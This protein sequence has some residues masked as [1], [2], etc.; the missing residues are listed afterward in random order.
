[1]VGPLVFLAA[2]GFGSEQPP[3]EV[4]VNTAKHEIVFRL[5]PFALPATSGMAEHEGM[6]HHGAEFPVYRFALPVGGWLRGFRIV[7]QDSAGQALPRRLLHHVNLLQLGRRQLTEPVFERTLGGGQETADVLLPK[8]VGIRVHAGDEMGLLTAWSN[9]AGCELPAVIL[10][11]SVPY[12]PENTVPHP[13]EVFP[14]V[15]D[16][17][18]RPGFPDDFDLDTGRTVH[19]RELVVPLDGHLLG[20]GGHLHDYAESLQLVEAGSGK[21][22]VALTPTLDSAGR[23]SGVSRKIFGISGPGLKLKA[24]RYLVVAVYRN[25]T[26]A[27][28]EHG[29]MAVIGGLFAPEDPRRWPAL[30]RTDAVFAADAAGLDRIGWSVVGMQLGKP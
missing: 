6:H 27:L 30:D 11:L 13:R 23:I 15:F 3:F 12:L 21:V 24:G 14:A 9:E 16:A 26:G 25:R 5:G 22:I 10:E 1:M 28:I 18:F 8:S 4:R 20:V 2:L 29:G 19:Q 17:G 7:I